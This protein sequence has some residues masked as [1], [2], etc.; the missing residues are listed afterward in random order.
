MKAGFSHIFAVLA[1]LAAA[2]VAAAQDAV[3]LKPAV[4]ITS[5]QRIT[6]ADVAHIEGS[7]AAELRAIVLREQAQVGS[8]ISLADIRAAIKSAK[9]VNGGRVALSGGDVSLV[10]PVATTPAAPRVTQPTHSTT[11]AATVLRVRD[12]LP[13][14]LA[15]TYGVALNEL[16][17]TFTDSDAEK[18]ATPLDN[19][20][21]TFAPQGTSDRP[22]V[23][24]RVYDGDTLVAAFT[25]RV[26]VMVQRE[27]VLAKADISRGTPLDAATTTREKRWMPLASNSA[28]PDEVAGRIAR[29]TIRAGSVIELRNTD[30]AIAVRKGD[31]VAVDCISGGIVLRSQMRAKAN[32]RVGEFVEFTPTTP[33]RGDRAQKR[34]GSSTERA[35]IKTIRARIAG[36]GRAV[37]V[38]TALGDESASQLREQDQSDARSVPAD[39]G[40]DAAAT[41][42][43]GDRPGQRT[44]VLPVYPS[45]ASKGEESRP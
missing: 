32:G 30:D 28:R 14:F 16:Q 11:N 38:T 40:T 31:L 12:A 6:L 8:T 9:S 37:V 19:R 15:H 2:C 35:Q 36:P 27:V 22:P 1:F 3:R 25:T 41:S 39:A 42:T 20:T 23:H 29:S 24:V 33:S 21:Y 45:P 10:A 34:A 4:T 7:Q 5:E 26:G 13:E 18:L 17:V 44:I 43:T